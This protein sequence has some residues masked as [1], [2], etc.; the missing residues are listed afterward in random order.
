MDAVTYPDSSVAAFIM[1]NIIPVRVKSDSQPLATDFNIKWTPSLITLDG[2][3]EEH[4]RTVGFLDPAQLIP[5]LILGQAKTA[6]DADQTDVALTFLGKLLDTYAK[7]DAAPE[8]VY[9]QGVCRY[10]STQDPAPL[11]G[12]YEK[13]AATWPENEWTR[14][15][16]PYRLL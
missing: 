14:R 1:E 10:K 15:A 7:S 2:K 13:L 16:Y 3:G 8:A 4:H 12:A 11:K 9:L 5:S 6:F